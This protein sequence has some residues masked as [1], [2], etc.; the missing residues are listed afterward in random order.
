MTVEKSRTNLLTMSKASRERKLKFFKEKW[1]EPIAFAYDVSE[2]ETHCMYT[3][4]G[5]IK[6]DID[7]YPK[8]DKL[9]LHGLNEWIEN[10]LEWLYR[11]CDFDKL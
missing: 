5:T 11:N 9:M 6:G 3:I 8:A 4:R 2:S 1:L 7:Y 10:G